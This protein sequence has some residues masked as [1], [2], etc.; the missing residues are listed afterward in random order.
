MV[1]SVCSITA[2]TQSSSIVQDCR[3]DVSWSTAAGIAD[4]RH[5]GNGI[6]LL[7][8][9]QRVEVGARCRR[10]MT[11]IQPLEESQANK[12]SGA[13]RKISSTRSYPPVIIAGS[14]KNSKS[15]TAVTVT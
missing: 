3:N 11:H 4:G 15:W 6:C 2:A 14:A 9:R 13:S 8:G 1:R 12:M 5:L 10:Q 7:N